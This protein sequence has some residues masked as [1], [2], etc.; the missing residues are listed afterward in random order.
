MFTTTL[1]I[2]EV[3]W[4]LEKAYKVPRQKI[5]ALV[6]K[7]LNTSH[8]HIDEKDI[9]LAAMGLYELKRIDFIDAYNAVTMEFKGM[10]AIYSYDRDFDILAPLK[11]LEP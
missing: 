9:L 11:R 4:A 7:I 6:Q 1:V 3:I 10:A 2:A 5:T 8:I